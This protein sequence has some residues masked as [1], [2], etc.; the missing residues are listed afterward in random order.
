M[1]TGKISDLNLSINRFALSIEM[2]RNKKKLF[3]L[4]IYVGVVAIII[5]VTRVGC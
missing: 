1:M 4:V 5:I 2:K 3:P